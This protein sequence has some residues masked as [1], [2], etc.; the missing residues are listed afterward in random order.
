MLLIKFD[1]SKA[2]VIAIITGN[3][4][5]AG[6]H[7]LAEFGKELVTPVQVFQCGVA[8]NFSAWVY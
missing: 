1:F 2:N 8:V 4:H 6:A 3:D 7:L 5:L